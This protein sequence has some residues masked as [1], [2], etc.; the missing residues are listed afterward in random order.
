MGRIGG[1]GGGGSRYRPAKYKTPNYNYSSAQTNYPSQGEINKAQKQYEKALEKPLPVHGWAKK[2]G[3][4]PGTIEAALGDPTML[5]G[6]AVPGYES[7]NTFVSD[8][9]ERQPMTDLAMISFGAQGKGLSTKTPTPSLP[10]TLKKIGYKPI[11]PDYKRTLDPSEVANKVAAMWRSLNEPG[12]S[13]G[14]INWM[15]RDKLVRDL[16]SADGKSILRQNLEIQFDEDPN[17]A[18]QSAASYLR[19]AFSAGPDTLISRALVEDVD[20]Q[21]TNMGSKI[22]RMKPKKASGAVNALARSYLHG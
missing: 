11:K 13:Y 5:L 3:F 14:D 12:V 2:Q 17:A 9:I 4:K 22:L 8:A 21:I 10:G 1:G 20:H 6:A 16:A 15:D 19:S 7:R 18:M